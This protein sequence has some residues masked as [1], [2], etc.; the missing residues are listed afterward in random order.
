[1]RCS[2]TFIAGV[3][4]T[5]ISSGEPS[6]R[7]ANWPATWELGGFRL[8]FDWKEIAGQF[9]DDDGRAVWEFIHSVLPKDPLYVPGE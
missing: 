7:P 8:K 4:V 1:L 5:K 3:L 2:A 6:G 9:V